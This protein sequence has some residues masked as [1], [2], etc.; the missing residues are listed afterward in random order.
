MDQLVS[1]L[2]LLQDYPSVPFGY[3]DFHQPYCDIYDYNNP[4]EVRNC[5]L[6]SLNDLNGGTDYVRQ[7]VADYI[8][9]LISIGVKGFR[10]DASKH[11]W[12]GIVHF[13]EAKAS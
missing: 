7:K 13:F 11:M 2:P 3:N 9:D 12:P 5:Y 10:F 8:N 6:V 4:D 1:T